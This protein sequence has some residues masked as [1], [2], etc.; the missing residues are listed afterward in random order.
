MK[1]RIFQMRSQLIDSVIRSYYI[2]FMAKMQI[3]NLKNSL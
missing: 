2:G 1:N 3:E